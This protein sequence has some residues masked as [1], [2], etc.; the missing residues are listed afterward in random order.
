MI[1]CCASLICH[2]PEKL[3]H[4]GVGGERKESI[5]PI[6]VTGG[7]SEVSLI[8]SKGRPNC[9]AIASHPWLVFTTVSMQNRFLSSPRSRRMKLFSIWWSVEQ[10]LALPAIGHGVLS[11]V[12]ISRWCLSKKKPASPSVL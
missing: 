3:K 9:A 8:V 11:P 10:V 12:S 6:L 7:S 5:Q 2:R 1:F 4:K